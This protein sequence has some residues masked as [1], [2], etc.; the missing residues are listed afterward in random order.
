MHQTVEAIYEDG[1]IKPLGKLDLPERARLRLKITPLSETPLSLRD[2]W[3]G[4]RD[5][6]D[7]DFQAAERLWEEGA[8]EAFRSLKGASG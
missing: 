2:L 8:E 5:L 7:E 1:V 4:A 3:Q 6:S